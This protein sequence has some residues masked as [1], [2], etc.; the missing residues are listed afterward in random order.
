MILSRSLDRNFSK[1]TD[2]SDL[3]AIVVVTISVRI[4]VTIPTSDRRISSEEE[5]RQL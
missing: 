3:D 2:I 5:I 4:R 1:N